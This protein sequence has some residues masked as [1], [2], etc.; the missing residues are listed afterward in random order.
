MIEEN[1]VDIVKRNGEYYIHIL[2]KAEMVNTNQHNN[3][4]VQP[5]KVCGVDPGVR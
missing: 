4:N 1:N 5:F 2:T 3:N